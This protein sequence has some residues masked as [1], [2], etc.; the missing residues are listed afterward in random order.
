MKGEQKKKQ[1]FL[2]GIGLLAAAGCLCYQG[3]KRVDARL[4]KKEEKD[5]NKN[6]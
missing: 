1:G 4:R 6:A 5:R 3:L 2:G